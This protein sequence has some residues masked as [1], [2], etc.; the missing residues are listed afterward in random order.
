MIGGDAIVAKD[1]F[2]PGAPAPAARFAGL[3]RYN[4]VYG[5]NDPVQVPAD[6]LAACAASVLSGSG[7]LLGMYNLGQA[8]QGHDAL[9]DFVA[10]KL[11]RRSG[12]RCT[13][14]DVL[15][16]SGSL[17]AMDL[18]NHV[19]IGPGDTVILEEFTYGGAIAKVERLG[20]KVVGAKLDEGGIVVEALRASLADL[21][22]R[23]VRPRYIYTIPTV[24]NP[25]G[26]IMGL[27]RR[28][29][30][31]ALAREF[32]V[33]IF[34][35][36][37]YADLVWAGER[38]PALYGLDPGNVI[39]IGS[40][41]KS[42]AP[43]LRIGYAVADWEVLGRMVASKTDAGSGALEQMVVAEYVTRN[44]DAHVAELTAG[45]REKLDV[46]VDALARE[47]GTAAELSRPEGGIFLW[48]KLPDG[49]DV[50]SFAEAALAQGLAFN[51][52]P[53]WACDPEAA[54]S[55]IRLC[56]ALPSAAQI[57]EGVAELARISFEHTGIPE[58]SGNLR[59]A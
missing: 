19:M 29:A 51:P 5:H 13:G 7:H 42:L 41:S 39:H 49:I 59:R 24:Q 9:R 52:G 33:P 31:L 20:A 16:T 37:C 30:L 43:A 15:I 4:F 57:R 28:R 53:E 50:R 18:V 55:H 2:R 58:R 38:P 40:F 17:Q 12:I 21:A 36:E 46:L 56:Y 14:D 34:E 10:E 22:G 11:A 6:E 1:W 48:L 25:T 23:G 44:F 32:G 54:K 47:F 35:D 45:L 27:E 26:S 3:P 8:P